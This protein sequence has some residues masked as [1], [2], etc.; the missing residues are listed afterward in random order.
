M[1]LSYRKRGDVWHCRG[2]VRVGRQTFAV[3][4]FSTGSTTKAEAEAVGAA[5]QAR[6]RAEV[7]DTGNVKGP[8]RTVLIRD[9][10]TAY[11][12]RPGKL[13]PFDIQR[14]DELDARMGSMPVEST[15]EAWGVWLRERAHDLAPST[16]AR[17][18]STL[19]AA[20]NYGADEFGIPA[21]TIRAVR[22][23]ELERIAYLTPNLEA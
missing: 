15:R 9:C 13:H 14:L 20:L 3:R 4:E 8:S 22:G 2:T 16:V 5:E 17:W 11:R 7:L 18:R 19:L 12:A 21:P 1:A 23:A 10:I 6:L